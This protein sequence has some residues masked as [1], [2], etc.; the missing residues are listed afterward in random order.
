[1][2]GAFWEMACCLTKLIQINTSPGLR[3]SM[4]GRLRGETGPMSCTRP[5]ASRRG[6]DP[7]F[8]LPPRN[9]KQEANLKKY[10]NLAA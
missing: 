9:D 10:G 5:I 8:K 3:A 1:M 2:L 4:G 6:A 7:M